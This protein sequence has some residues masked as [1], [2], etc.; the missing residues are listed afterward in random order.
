[1][2]AP[3][4]L[5]DEMHRF[6]L[7]AVWIQE[8]DRIIVFAIAGIGS[9]RIDDLDFFG[10]EMRVDRIDLIARSQFKRIVVIADAAG[11]MRVANSLR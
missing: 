1:M 7:Q 3:L 5:F 11:M 8:E 4:L 9:R 2:R 6:E 10:E